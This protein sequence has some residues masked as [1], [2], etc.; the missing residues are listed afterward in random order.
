MTSIEMMDDAISMRYRCAVEA[1]SFGFA[2]NLQETRHTSGAPFSEGGKPR[3]QKMRRGERWLVVDNMV[4]THDVVTSEIVLKYEP[5]DFITQTTWPRRSIGRWSYS[6]N[7][8]IEVFQIWNY[9][10]IS[11]KYRTV[12]EA[13]KHAQCCSAMMVA[14]CCWDCRLIQ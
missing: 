12:P 14:G 11:A 10:S 7:P 4:E 13:S 9:Y 1:L 5:P 6:S 8:V 2:A 3:R